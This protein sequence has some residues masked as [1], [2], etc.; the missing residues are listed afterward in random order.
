MEGTLS[1]QSH[2]SPD[3]TLVQ[4][5]RNRNSHFIVL[6]PNRKFL[7]VPLWKKTFETGHSIDALAKGVMLQPYK[8]QVVD[9]RGHSEAERRIAGPYASTSG[10]ES[11]IPRAA[12]RRPRAAA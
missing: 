12:S 1:K 2:A 4:V 9:G 7:K 3:L 5:E 11:H 6:R 8:E 10:E